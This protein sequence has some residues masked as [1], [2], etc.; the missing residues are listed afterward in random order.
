MITSRRNLWQM[1]SDAVRRTCGFAHNERGTTAVEFG[2]LAV[3]FF[4]LVGAILET[5]LIFLAGQ[6]LDS[7]VNDSSRLIRTGQAHNNTFSMSE[8][9]SA[10]CDELFGLFD[11]SQLRVKVTELGTFTAAAPSENIVDEDTGDW[12]ISESYDAGGGSSIILVEA[13]YK[14]PTYLNIFGFDLASLPD[15]TRLLGAVRIFR[16][17]PFS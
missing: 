8:Y 6:V 15:Q 2:L 5:A 14:W 1:L 13:Y 17:E 11:C 3:P 7:A 16:N 4:A 10:I 9:K 12:E